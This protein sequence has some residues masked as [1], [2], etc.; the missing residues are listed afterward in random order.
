MKKLCFLIVFFCCIFFLYRAQTNSGIPSD[1][2][3]KYGEYFYNRYSRHFDE[4]GLS[5]ASPTYGVEDLKEPVSAREWM[6]LASY[7]KYRAQNGD[8][9]AKQVLIQA[10]GRATDEIQKRPA[11]T[12]SFND[13]EALF[14][15]IRMIE[16]IPGVLSDEESNS[17]LIYLVKNIEEG[18]K[19]N[20]TENRALIAG[21]H[22]QYIVDYIFSHGF[23]SKEQKNH[24][25]ELIKAKIDK[26]IT[27]SI[28]V[29]EG[30]Y[31]EGSDKAFSVHYHAISAFMLMV[32]G[33]FT[34]QVAYTELAKKMYFN[35]KKIS[36]SNGMVEARLGNRPIGLGAQFY[37]AMGL[38]GQYNGDPDYGVYFLYGG[39]NRFF[40]DKEHKQRLEF[41][42]TIQFS[43]PQYHDDYAFSDVL[44]LGLVVKNL[45]DTPVLYRDRMSQPIVKSKDTYF[46]I[47]NFGTIILVNN[48]I[49]VQ[50]NS[51]V[52]SYI[53]T[54]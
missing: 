9:K 19:A 6:S 49:N 43:E 52:K 15:I 23:I 27:E 18:I 38:L 12:Q 37:T 29:Q 42:S 21:A 2:L 22:W 36:F 44:E 48:H 3:D 28:A 17:L 50:G 25:D 30:W 35:I 10:I 11:Y 33:D 32:Y 1:T 39:R 45:K 47:R 31:F 26:G 41:H 14:L 53:F 46:T 20:D 8:E 16:S 24:L 40:S 13:A 5:Y 34:N 51:R 54:K 7:Y 4:N